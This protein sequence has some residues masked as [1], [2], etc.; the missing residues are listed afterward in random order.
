M[1]LLLKSDYSLLKSGVQKG[2]DKRGN[3]P[4]Q[5][6]HLLKN[7]VLLKCYSQMLL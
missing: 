4:G 5:K 1:L 6:T 3:G 2:V 7:Y